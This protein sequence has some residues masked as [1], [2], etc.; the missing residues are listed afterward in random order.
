M[1]ETKKGKYILVAEDDPTN[2]YVFR[3]I[4]ERAGYD[5]EIAEHGQKALEACKA[6]R[7][8]LILMD[9]MMPI[10]NGYETVAIMVQDPNLDD[11][12]ILA[13]T[14]NAM[15]G[16]EIKT[17]EAGCDDHIAKPVQMKEF[18]DKIESWLKR[19]PKTWMPARIAGREPPLSAT[20]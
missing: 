10:L 2:Q 8:D 15:R 1:I 5:V 19:D 6:R 12:P 4:L 20:G 9:M 17:R 3:K 11:I 16:D 7:P 13:L 14:A 18:L